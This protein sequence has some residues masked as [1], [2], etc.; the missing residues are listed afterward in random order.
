MFVFV[1]V[2]FVLKIAIFTQ[3]PK[4]NYEARR[5]LA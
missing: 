4:P 2:L 5:R 1:F 3:T